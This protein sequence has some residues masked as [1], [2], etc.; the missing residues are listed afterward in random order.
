MS[1]KLAVVDDEILFRKGLIFLLKANPNFEVIFEGGNG[2]ELCQFLDST[3]EKPDIILLDIQMP[4]QNG[5]ETAK[6]LAES[7]PSIHVIILSSFESEILIEQMIHF[8]AASYLVKNT[9]PAEMVDTI[10]LVYKNGIFLPP[11][12]Q[13]LLAGKQAVSH[14]DILGL[15]DREIEVLDLIY[16]QHNA[17]EIAKML[18][19][20]ERTVE[21]HRQNMLR[22][23]NSKNVAGLILY[24]IK[25]NLI[26]AI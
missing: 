8:G 19:I 25:N 15:T 2:L 17:A 18:Y 9:D 13:K 4:V 16:K 1:I 6:I 10:Q 22:K 12:L 24:G 20:S 14:T 3:T 21:T 11:K 7:H 23:T 26:S 5:V